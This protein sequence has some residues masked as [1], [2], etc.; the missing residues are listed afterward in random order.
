MNLKSSHALII[1]W[2]GEKTS[3]YHHYNGVKLTAMN[4]LLES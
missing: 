1:F 2:S 3:G 4:R